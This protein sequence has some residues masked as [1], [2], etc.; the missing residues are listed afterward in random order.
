[1]AKSPYNPKRDFPGPLGSAKDDPLTFS[2]PKREL[3]ARIQSHKALYG[4]ARRRQ[5][6]MLQ[7]TLD[8]TNPFKRLA[9]AHRTLKA[10]YKNRKLGETLY[11]MQS[12]EHKR[13]AI[14]KFKA[15][16]REY[17]TSSRMQKPKIKRKK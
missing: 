13:R 14:G 1:M 16:A 5:E 17:P 11:K 8:Q 9:G 3:Q 2:M 10:A 4:K 15:L 12:I 6:T 7:D